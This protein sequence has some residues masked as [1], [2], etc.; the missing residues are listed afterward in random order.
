MTDARTNGPSETVDSPT[1]TSPGQG[2][3]RAITGPARF[4]TLT[5]RPLPGTRAWFIVY[6]LWMIGWA[7][8][9]RFLLDRAEQEQAFALPAWLLALMCFYLSLCNCFMPLPT[10][11]IILLAASPE[12]ALVQ[13]G[14]LRVLVVSGLA[15]MATVVANLNEY[16]LLAYLLRFGL[17]SRIRRTQ[18]YGWAIRW[19]DRAPFQLLTLLAFIPIPVDAVRWLAILRSYPR[20]RFALAYLCGRG[21]RYLLFAWCSVLLEFRG[22]QILAIQAG[23][24]VAALAARLVW[25]VIRRPQSGLN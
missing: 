15:T 8:L 12:Y 13:A 22:W 17:G 3:D 7:T 6:V 1:A 16:H 19:F 20:V 10:A 25:R 23:L 4:A 18:V 5:E 2:L 14:W 24:I 9:A 11:W 21:P